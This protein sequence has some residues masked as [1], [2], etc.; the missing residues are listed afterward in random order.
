MAQLRNTLWTVDSFDYALAQLGLSMRLASFFRRPA[1]APGSRA[2]RNRSRYS[3][4]A[5]RALRAERGCGR[6]PHILAKRCAK[7]EAC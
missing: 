3:G 7:V 1:G 5:L 2:Y 4:E 6:P